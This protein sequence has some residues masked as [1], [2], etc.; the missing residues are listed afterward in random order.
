MQTS[1]CMRAF[2]GNFLPLVRPH[3]RRP[4]FRAGSIR[5]A[6][7]HALPVESALPSH[8]SD[9]RPLRASAPAHA[10]NSGWRKTPSSAPSTASPPANTRTP[11]PT[12]SRRSPPLPAAPQRRSIALSLTSP[13][14]IPSTRQPSIARSICP[15]NVNPG[16][17]DAPAGASNG[18]VVI[19]DPD[20]SC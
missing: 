1:A 16:R 18:V 4:A 2:S 11:S 10:A 6:G 15:A 5:H 8:P 12:D 17:L 7:G 13:H 19:L 14:P 9:P 20:S 3:P